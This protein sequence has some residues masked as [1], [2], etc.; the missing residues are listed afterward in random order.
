YK[1][2]EAGEKFSGD[3][4]SPVPDDPGAYNSLGILHREN[5][6]FKKAETD[7]QKSIALKPDFSDAFLNLGILNEL[8]LGKLADALKN[9]KEYVKSGGKRE[10]VLVWI[11]ILEKRVG[12]K[13]KN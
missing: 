12:V 3:V 13:S 11:N 6:E 1:R 7:Y 5:G 2:T 8:Y 9:Y 10:D 4:S